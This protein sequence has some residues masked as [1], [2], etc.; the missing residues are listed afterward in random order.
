MSRGK[1][2]ALPDAS[3]LLRKISQQLYNFVRQDLMIPS[4]LGRILLHEEETPV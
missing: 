3:H 1:Y 2:T 4:F